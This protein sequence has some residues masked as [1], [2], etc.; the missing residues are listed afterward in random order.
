MDCFV[1]D[2]EM[3][4]FLNGTAVKKLPSFYKNRIYHQYVVSV[5]SRTLDDG[6]QH[7]HRRV[8]SVFITSELIDTLYGFCFKTEIHIFRSAISTIT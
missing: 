5:L 3:R 2:D 8:I 6:R 4:P 1:S 7:E